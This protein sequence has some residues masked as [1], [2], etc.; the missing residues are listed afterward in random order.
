MELSERYPG[1]HV[2]TFLPGVVATGFGLNALGGGLDSR[3]IPGGQSPEEAATV[4]LELIERPRPDVYSRP[5]FRQAVAAYYA[6]EDLDVP[7]GPLV[8]RP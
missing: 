2:S 6:S 7:T 5:E 8:K 1:I 4:L 3:K